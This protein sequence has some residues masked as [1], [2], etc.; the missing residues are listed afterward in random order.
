MGGFAMADGAV[1]L[2]GGAGIVVDGTPCALTT[3]GH[4]KTG[5]MVGFTAASCGGPAS[6]VTAVGGA[7]IGSVVADEDSPKYAVSS[8][9]PPK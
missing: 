5:E 2:D 9:T 4:D 6:E 3:I 7:N 1:P 8:S